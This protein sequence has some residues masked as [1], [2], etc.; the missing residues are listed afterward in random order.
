[1]TVDVAPRQ[2]EL[3]TGQRR[4]A[5]TR[6][7]ERSIWPVLRRECH[8][9]FPGEMFA[10]STAPPPFAAIRSCRQTALAATSTVAGT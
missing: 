5:G 6:A 9:L 4:F 3:F 8:R 1:M 7:G 10:A 2:S